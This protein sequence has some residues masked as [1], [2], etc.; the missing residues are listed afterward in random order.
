MKL[1]QSISDGF[2]QK[3]KPQR[4]V[5]TLLDYSKAY[6]RTWHERLLLKLSD[7]GAPLQMIRWIAAFVR[8]RTDKKVTI[9]G[10]LSK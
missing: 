2:Q 8:T 7:L 9:N 3:P 1:V 4:A 10:T 6:D 5:M